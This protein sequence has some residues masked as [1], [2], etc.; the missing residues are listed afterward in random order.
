MDAFARQYI[1]A[2]A[3]PAGTFYPVGVAIATLTK[4]KIE[5]KHNFSLSAVSSAGSGENIR[6]L[7]QNRAQFAI[8]QGLYGAWAW[9]GTGKLASD[10]RQTYLRSITMLWN[11]VEHFV[12]K[13]DYVKT[14][15]IS[16]LNGLKNKWFSLGPKESGTEGSGSYILESL[17]FRPYENFKISTNTYGSNAEAMLD[18]SIEGMNIPG[19]PPV[20]AVTQV[21]SALGKDV[22]VLNITDQ[23][24]QRIDRGFPL[25]HRFIIPAGTYPGQDKPIRTIAQPN[26]MAVRNDIPVDVVYLITKTIYQNLPFL[27]YIHSGTRS[28]SLENAIRGLTVPLHP[29]AARFYREQGIDIP[30]SL[31]SK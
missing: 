27:H 4:I 29:G 23:Q 7:R 25:W 1:L 13:S 14:G 19:G 9:N 21:F 22:T 20:S 10:G 18:G 3:T 2:T 30:D 17:G 24:L 15:N 28:I 31:I 26:F 8:L 11:N 12:I 5:P 6:M 16:D